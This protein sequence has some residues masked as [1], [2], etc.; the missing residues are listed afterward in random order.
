M[1]WKKRLQV[2]LVL[3]SIISSSMM[4][5]DYC[6]VDSAEPFF[7]L[8]YKAYV[9]NPFPDYANLVKQQLARIGIN[10]EIVI[11]HWGEFLDTLLGSR[12][13]DI[14]SI[15]FGGGG[16]D[17]GGLPQA[18][19]RENS[20]L[21]CFGYNTSMDYDE[22]LGTGKN[23]WYIRNIN[24]FSQ[25]ESQERLDHYQEWENY[26][27]DEICPLLPMFAP[28]S[29][30]IHYDNL[31]GYN[32]KDGLLDSW[33][34]LKWNGFHPGQQSLDEVVISDSAQSYQNPFF[35][36]D[37]PGHGYLH[38]T[39]DQLIDIDNDL[40]I[41]PHIAESWEYISD[42]HL[43]FTIREGIKWENDPDNN[44]TNEYVDAKDVYFTLYCWK[45]VSVRY[46]DWYWLEDFQIV[47]N[48]TID[49]FIDGD[50]GTP[51]PDTYAPA[52]IDLATWIVPEHY[53]NQTQEPDG[54]TPDI[55][56]PSW[57]IYDEL[58][59][60][61]KLFR[62]KELTDEGG[63]IFELRSDSWWFNESITNDPT[64]NWVERFGTF[65]HSPSKVRIRIIPDP[66]TSLLEFQ[67]GTVDINGYSHFDYLDDWIKENNIAIQYYTTNF[68]NWLGYNMRES[69]GPIGSREPAPLDPSLTIGLAI[70][71]AISYA[72]NREEIND[73]VHEWDY[74]IWNHP[75]Y[76]T[77]G[78]WLNPN[79]IRYDHN[80]QLAKEYMTKAG[81]HLV[82]LTIKVPLY[83]IF[84]FVGIIGLII[85]RKKK[86]K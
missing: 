74:K 26:F 2:C 27:M 43:R 23:E 32:Y 18:A 62:I 20:N 48:R 63:V 3:Y 60:G 15:G 59:F 21:N 71:K 35:Y 24:N 80:L 4:V 55:T 14:T 47:D 70:R 38:Y 45:E 29:R 69:R 83:T 39:L 73:I 6:K 77:L 85:L 81:Y 25:S 76:P 51:E 75:N 61:S 49:I 56:H 12:D 10:V 36:C 28:L 52:L 33:G 8:T 78:K 31:E 9:G 16:A 22:E 13:F 11:E 7:T 42:S 41:W 58:P 66:H 17:P 53:L 67:K 19:Y 1:F 68:Y 54:I 44:F 37:C 46:N 82:D 84:G 30:V 65:E 34:K 64:L 86:R 57:M 50:S 5:I 40:R 79:I 72:I